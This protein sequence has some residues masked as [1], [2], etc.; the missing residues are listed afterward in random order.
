VRGVLGLLVCLAF[1]SFRRA[2][3]TTLGRTTASLLVLI[4]CSQ[5][6]F[7]FYASRPLPNTFALVPALFAFRSW[8]LGRHAPFIWSSAAAIVLFRA[9]LAGLLGIMMMV[10]VVRGRCGVWTLFKHSVPAGL[11]WLGLTVGVDS[12]FWGRW[13]W[14]EGEV[15]WFNTVLNK[16]RLWGTKPIWW[17]FASALPRSL[18]LPLL[19]L[20]VAVVTEPRSRLPLLCALVYVFLYSLLP[21]KEL[22]FIVYTIPLFNVVAALAY[23]NIWK[24]R[25]KLPVFVRLGAVCSLLVS[26]G[27]ALCFLSVSRHNYPGGHAMSLLHRLV[28]R[29]TEMKLGGRVSVHVGVEAAM[30]GVSRFGEERQSWNYS[31]RE[32]LVPGSAEMLEFDFLL[33]SVEDHHYYQESHDLVGRSEGFTRLDWS[34]SLFPPL[35]IVL[36]DR[37]LVLAK[38][39]VGCKK[40]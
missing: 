36:Q 10:E 6:H 25:R 38:K 22:R 34:P 31:K 23:S 20:P 14:P 4:T 13:V 8:L 33:I 40:I 39:S 28:D 5:F 17:Y 9:E 19:S 37:I 12:V 32:D 3:Q 1:I 24:N 21:H 30:T 35:R 26:F 16:S 29:D 18:L 11:L 2:V 7:L 27:V 15:L